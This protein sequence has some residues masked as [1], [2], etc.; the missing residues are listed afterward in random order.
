MAGFTKSGFERHAGGISLIEMAVVLACFCVILSVALPNLEKL[1]QEWTLWG[2]ALLVEGSLQWGRMY[3][4]SANT[5]V[6]FEI[7]A[8]G[9]RFYW[10]NPTTGEVYDNTIRDL[11]GNIR[12]VSSPSRPLRYFPRGTA[13][14]AGT[15]ILRGDAGQYRV[16]VNPAGRVRM[17]RD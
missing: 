10:A 8:G 15:F 1:N 6:A 3:A 9:R 14:P 5:S 11:P 7:D 2:G 4:I 16:V 12:V 17:Q 13:A